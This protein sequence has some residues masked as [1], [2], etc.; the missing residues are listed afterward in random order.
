MIANL[1]GIDMFAKIQNIVA[2][3]LIF[4]LVIMG[5]IG[6]MGIGTGEKVVQEFNLATAPGEVFGLVGLAFFLF[7]GSEFIIPIAKDVKNARRNIPLGMVISLLVVCGMQILV[8]LGMHNYTDWS[9]LATDSSPHIFYG[10]SLLGTIGTTWM[11]IVSAFAVISTVNTV[12]SSLPYI[13]AGMAKINLLP[14]I[15]Q[16]R[17]KKGVPY[18][19]V[20]S[21]GGVM[22]VINA[23]GLSTSNQLSF[24]ILIGC[25]F[26]MVAYI[27]SNINVLILRKRLPDAPRTFKVPLGPILPILGVIG[28][29]FMIWHIEGDSDV[30]KQIYLICLSV[31]LVISIYAIIWIKRVMKIKLMKPVEMKDVMAME[32]DLYRITRSKKL[33]EV[34]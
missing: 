10:T 34:S 23:T 33:K 16:K 13:C 11:I 25:V 19:G 15:F 8:L 32:N 2:Y 31:F 3:G 30:R 1:N 12:I 24:M 18:I 22:I 4:S 28:N 27:I 20:L 6:I 21:V 5:I 7:L 9:E 29:G 17:N 26:W 14:A